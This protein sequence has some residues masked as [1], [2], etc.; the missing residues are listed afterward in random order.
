MKSNQE[1]IIIA[2]TKSAHIHQELITTCGKFTA[3]KTAGLLDAGRAVVAALQAL[4]NRAKGIP[5]PKEG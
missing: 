5:N 3:T 1:L 4:D 2:L